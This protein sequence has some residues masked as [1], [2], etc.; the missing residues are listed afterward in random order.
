MEKYQGYQYTLPSPPTVRDKRY[1]HVFSVWRTGEL[2]S[3]NRMFEIIPK[4]VVA[5]DLGM[6]YHSFVNKLNRPHLLN[7]NHLLK[8]QCLTGIE[9]SAL[10]G[11][12]V[13][14]IKEKSRQQ[15]K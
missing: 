4:S 14:D 11:L 13:A 6:H 7:V 2:T 3:L 5:D 1:N 8:L 9:I 12:A 15:I 10:I